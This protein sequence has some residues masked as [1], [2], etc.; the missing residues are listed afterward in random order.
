[1][2]R[3]W[4]LCWQRHSRTRRNLRSN[5]QSAASQRRSRRRWCQF[6]QEWG[7]FYYEELPNYAIIKP[8]VA[9]SRASTALRRIPLLILRRERATRLSQLPHHSHIEFVCQLKAYPLEMK[10][11][12]KPA[13]KPKLSATEIYR[14]RAL[15]PFPHFKTNFSLCWF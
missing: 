9:H 4:I 5:C 13:L 6:W 8:H 10:T 12:L 7:L 14:G 2:A 3:V 15:F 1:M 11:E